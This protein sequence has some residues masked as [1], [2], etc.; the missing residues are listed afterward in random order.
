V[1]VWFDALVNYLSGLGF[2]RPS[3]AWERHWS[4]DGERVHV[5]GKNITRFHA[6]YWPAI[7]LSAGLP[8]PTTLVVHG[9]VTAG[10]RKISKS[11]GDAIEPRALAERYGTDGLR[12]LLLRRSA[13]DDVDLAP[14]AQDHAH[15]AELA[16]QLGNLVGR[17][18]ALIDGSFGGVVPHPSG[19]PGP[20]AARARALRDDVAAAVRS[21]EP[22]RGLAAARALVAEAN[23]AIVADEPWVLARRRPEDR[24]ADARLRTCLHAQASVLVAVARALVPLLPDTAAAIARRLGVGPGPNHCD[25]AGSIVEPGPPLFPKTRIASRL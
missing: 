6:V 21:F 4:G 25:P 13:F 24:D 12:Y 9:F 14:E 5:I 11:S 3:A 8:L 1:Y 20:L 16:D 19:P 7:L 23:R 15:D 17:V 22:D 18:I 10:G 2:P